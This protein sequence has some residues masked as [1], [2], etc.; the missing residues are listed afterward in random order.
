MYNYVTTDTIGRT[1]SAGIW[2]II[3]G[4][5]A[6]VGG[7][8]VYFLFLTK[9]NDKKLEGKAKWAYDFLQF[10]KLFAEVLLKIA[11]LITAIYITL[12]SFAMI[13]IS[14]IGFLLYLVI[15]N[16]VAR[17]GYEFAL[18]LLTICKNTTEINAK[19]SKPEPAKPKAEKEKK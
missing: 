15:G 5:L 11:Y 13:G 4:V 17:L 16:V 18:V 7:L 10:R 2:M 3:S 19:L 9:E 6:V 1:A 8:V 14:F 12:S